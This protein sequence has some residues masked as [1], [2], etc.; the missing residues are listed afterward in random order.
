M[1]LIVV[2]MSKWKINF[3]YLGYWIGLMIGIKLIFN[4]RV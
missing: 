1:I 2:V 4:K 3:I